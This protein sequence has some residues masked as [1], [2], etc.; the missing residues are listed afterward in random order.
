MLSTPETV[1]N[2]DGSASASPEV[3]VSD[4]SPSSPDGSRSSDSPDRTSS[5]SPSRGGENQVLI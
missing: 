1:M 5:P 2:M 3:V 4:P